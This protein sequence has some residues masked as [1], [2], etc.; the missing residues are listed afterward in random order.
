M[1]LEVVTHELPIIGAQIDATRAGVDTVLGAAQPISQ[2]GLPCGDLVSAHV[3]AVGRLMNALYFD[4]TTNPGVGHLSPG[5][6]ALRQSASCYEE[7]DVS[8]G[9][10]V[11][12]VATFAV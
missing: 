6:Q 12:G 1:S 2:L 4:Q 10:T 3:H 9:A 11:S 8:G 7:S 5:A